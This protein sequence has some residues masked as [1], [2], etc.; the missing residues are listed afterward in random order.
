M[1][2]KLSKD[3]TTW[4]CYSAGNLVATIRW[5]NARGAY[6]DR[7]GLTLGNN[8]TKARELAEK[9]AAKGQTRMAL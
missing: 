8:F 3:Q 9:G 5:D 1:N 4:E 7:E 2:W 6:L